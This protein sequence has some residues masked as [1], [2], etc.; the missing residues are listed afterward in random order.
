LSE[1]LYSEGFSAEITEGDVAQGRAVFYEHALASCIRCHRVGDEGGP[2]GPALDG[3]ASRKSR[4]Y[5]YQS[6]IQP[7]AELAEGFQGGVSPMPPM[8]LLLNPQEFADLM[9]FLMTLK[10]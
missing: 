6:L 9:G 10:N 4:D 3:I 5:I 8:N 7:N 1:V 2:V